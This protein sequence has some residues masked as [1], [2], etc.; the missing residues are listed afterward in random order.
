MM[1]NIVPNNVESLQIIGLSIM[2][3]IVDPLMVVILLAKF[4]LGK[5]SNFVEH[6]LEL[7]P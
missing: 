4:G 1:G 5:F 3:N 7:V 6:V 2:F